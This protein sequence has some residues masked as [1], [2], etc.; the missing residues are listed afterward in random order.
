M[1]PLFEDGQDSFRL[2]LLV[3]FVEEFLA[4]VLDVQMDRGGRDRAKVQ[5]SP[6]LL[7]TLALWLS[8]RRFAQTSFHRICKYFCVSPRLATQPDPLWAGAFRRF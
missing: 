8:L 4:K 6:G 5:T 7:S 3:R 1:P 2:L